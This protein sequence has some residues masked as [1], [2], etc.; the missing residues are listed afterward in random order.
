[1]LKS[2]DRVV[3]GTVPNSA[4]SDEMSAGLTKERTNVS[5]SSEGPKPISW[6]Q[7]LP[8]DEKMDEIPV[9]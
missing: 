8:K 1:M 4:K 6:E 3:R 2:F 5:K 9:K 7:N